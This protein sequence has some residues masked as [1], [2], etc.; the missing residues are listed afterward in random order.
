MNTR[1]L[2][3]VAVLALVVALGIGALTR[4]PGA[5]SAGIH[6]MEADYPVYDTFG[7]LVDSSALIVRGKVQEVRPS[8]RV[9]PEGV[10]RGELPAHKAANVGYLLTDVVVRVD[11]VLT[12]SADLVTSD[13]VVIHPGGE[14]GKQKYE[15]KDEPIAKKGHSYVFFLERTGDGRYV[16]VGGAQ[17][18]YLVQQGKL[19]DLSDEVTKLPVP[20]LLSG[21]DLET[22]ERDFQHLA[23]THKPKERPAQRDE[24]LRPD[25]KPK[26][27]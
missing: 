26:R 16:V 21:M 6:T 20:E 27:P 18:R 8:Y 11:R 23:K 24:P 10:P 2:L 9:I 15:M 1:L 17:G 7:S 19:K 4:G 3:P 13:I 14:D 25:A 22:L 12:G 5:D